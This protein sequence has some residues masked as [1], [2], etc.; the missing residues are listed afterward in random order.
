MTRT[1]CL[2]GATLLSFSMA[3]WAQAPTPTHGHARHGGPGGGIMHALQ[4]LDLEPGQR[5]LI[6]ARL[7]QLRADGQPLRDAAVELREDLHALVTAERWDASAATELAERRGA[8]AAERALLMAAAMHDV[9]AMLDDVQRTEL[10]AMREARHARRE[11]RRAR[12]SQESS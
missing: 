10:E 8:L 9:Y 1:I 12:R 4:Q 11:A 3:A 7:Q 6:Q 5:E 2:L